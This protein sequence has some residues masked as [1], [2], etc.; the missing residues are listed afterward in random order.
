[1]KTY[2]LLL[3]LLL[4]GCKHFESRHSTGNNTG[5]LCKPQCTEQQVNELAEPIF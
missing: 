3:V 1:M 5:Q 4:V 2:M